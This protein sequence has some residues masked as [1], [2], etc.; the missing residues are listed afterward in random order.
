MS[1]SY[2][3]VWS[4]ASKTPTERIINLILMGRGLRYTGFKYLAY[5]N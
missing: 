1:Q 5:I 4:L 3:Y 2:Q